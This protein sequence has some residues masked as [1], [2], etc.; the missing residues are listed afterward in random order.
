MT[1]A[2]TAIGTGVASIF[3]YKAQQSASEAQKKT[4]DAQV[5]I[6]KEQTK[7]ARG[8]ATSSITASYYNLQITEAQ[9]D[10]IVK[11][12]IILAIMLVL[13]TRIKTRK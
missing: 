12:A 6:A 9:Q 13:V 8:A 11:V 5:E 1:A 3:G 4:A 2:I 10:T 7:Q